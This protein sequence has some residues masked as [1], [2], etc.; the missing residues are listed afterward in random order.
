MHKAAQRT[1]HR[2]QGAVAAPK[3]ILCPVDFSELSTRAL[4]YAGTIAKWYRSELT[5][6]H[7]APALEP[8]EVLRAGELFDPVRFASPR[9]REQV[10]RQLREA[11]H[12]AGLAATRARAV[13]EAGDPSEV[14]VEQSVKTKAGLVVMATHG[15]S[16][17]NRL[18]LGSVAEKVLRTAPCPVLTVPPHAPPSPARAAMKTIL[19]A[20]DESP[21]AL[22][23]VRLAVDF[24]RRAKASV[25]FLRVVEW[26]AEEEPREIAHFSVPEIRGYLIRD[27][28]ERLKELIAQQPRIARGAVATV[29]MGRAYREILRIASEI[30]ADLI[31]MGAQGR[32]GPPLTPL[33]SATQ[34]VVRAASCP[35]LT[36]NAPGR[37]A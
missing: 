3:R 21:A 5:A 7:V 16:G 17:W 19:C 22:R 30:G 28:K 4:A 36:V 24:A 8:V 35:V 25:T 26:L 11:M 6:L 2:E 31:V 23:G 37:R 20:V 15:R 29:A 9:T 1:R 12:D 34:Q 13:A 27:A 32:G 10:E 14:I 18:M 33:G